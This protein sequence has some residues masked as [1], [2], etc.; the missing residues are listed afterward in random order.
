MPGVPAPSGKRDDFLWSVDLF[1]FDGEELEPEGVEQAAE[2][3]Q[4]AARAGG[5]KRGGGV[6]ADHAEDRAEAGGGV[7]IGA[8]RI[9]GLGESAKFEGGFW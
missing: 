5:V 8:Q 4:Q 3:I 1:F 7:E 9:S 6:G 2:G